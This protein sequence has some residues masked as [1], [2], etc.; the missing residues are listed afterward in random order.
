MLDDVKRNRHSIASIAVGG[1]MKINELN[2]LERGE[3]DCV[4]GYQALDGQSEAY[5]IGYG[6]QYAKEQTVGGQNEII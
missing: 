6:E 5:Q 3:Y 4:L 2:D 1:N